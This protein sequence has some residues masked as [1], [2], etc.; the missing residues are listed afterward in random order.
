M[1]IK[2]KGYGRTLEDAHREMPR[3]E[4]VG[5]ECWIREQTDMNVVIREIQ[6][7]AEERQIMEGSLGNLNQ[8]LENV[9]AAKRMDAAGFVVSASSFHSA[10][11]CCANQWEATD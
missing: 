3:A 6:L 2:D 10:L 7:A 5:D 8:V 11:L 1:G 9:L 4:H